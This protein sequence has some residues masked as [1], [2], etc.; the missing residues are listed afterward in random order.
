MRLGT[1]SD[2]DRLIRIHRC[3]DSA[4]V[5]AFVV[6]SV[7][8][9]EMLHADLPVEI[10]NGRRRLHTPEFRRRERL[11]HRFTEAESWLD[12]HLGTLA[13]RC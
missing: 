12:E 13:A 6:E 7:V 11:F 2:H 1:Y 9:H 3:L 10:H 5:P 4:D 8:Y